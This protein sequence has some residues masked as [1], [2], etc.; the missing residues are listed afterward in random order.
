MG[1]GN[2][3]NPQV[4]G[5]EERQGVS[6]GRGARLCSALGLCLLDHIPFLFILYLK[7]RVR[8]SEREGESEPFVGWFTA[9]MPTA[10]R[11]EPD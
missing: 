9:R 1:G 11:V 6:E 7:G 4:W 2:R 5:A 10:A 8:V 3:V